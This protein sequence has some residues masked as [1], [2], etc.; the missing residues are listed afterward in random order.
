M[1]IAQNRYLKGE[2]AFPVDYLKSDLK[3]KETPAILEATIRKNLL[4]NVV[5]R[6]VLGVRER[7]K[8]PK[9]KEVMDVYRKQRLENPEE[10]PYDAK[11]KFQEK[12]IKL[13]SQEEA[14]DEDEKDEKYKQLIETMTRVKQQLGSQ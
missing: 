13:Y 5:M 9:L 1:L 12:F 8:R 14:A 4:K 11:I 2:K 3:S 10:N 6:L 7:K